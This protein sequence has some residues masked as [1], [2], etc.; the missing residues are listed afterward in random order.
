MLE[1][2]NYVQVKKG[3][4]LIVL[5]ICIGVIGGRYIYK[6]KRINKKNLIHYMGEKEFRKLDLFIFIHNLPHSNEY[7]LN[8]KKLIN[9]VYAGSQVKKLVKNKNLEEFY[10]R[11]T[12]LK[13]RIETNDVAVE[14]LTAAIISLMTS[15][16]WDMISEADSHSKLGIIAFM[17]FITFMVFIIGIFVV[18]YIF[19]TRY[20][21]KGVDVGFERELFDYELN[22]IEEKIQ[23]IEE[24]LEEEDE[25][26]KLKRVAL[27][28]LAQL[29]IKG[30]RKNEKKELERTIKDI[31][32][33]ERD[34]IVT[35]YDFLIFIEN[36]K[37]YLYFDEA[38]VKKAY[39][40][41]CNKCRAENKKAMKKS[42][43]VKSIKEEGEVEKYL[44][45]DSKK[46]FD[47][48]KKYNIAIKI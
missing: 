24:S 34:N 32:E 33:I 31:A 38:K 23:E 6:F 27:C 37:V 3:F 28:K 5:L 21:Y 43:F 16:A 9:E 8:A 39:E 10:R 25:D 44:N 30:W 17:L 42:K 35:K 2:V 4:F 41:Y 11:K 7:Y 47:Y 36:D 13:N 29:E 18:V 12:F 26:Q 14:I 20:S 1:L 48:M 22:K 40:I 15:L 45:D 46:I 19:Y